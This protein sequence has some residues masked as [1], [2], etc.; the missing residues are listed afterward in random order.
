MD[1][2]GKMHTNL[3]RCFRLFLLLLLAR[4]LFPAVSFLHLGAGGKQHIWVAATQRAPHFPALRHRVK[5]NGDPAE[6]RVSQQ[7]RVYGLKYCNQVARRHSQNALGG[8]VAPKQGLGCTGWSPAPHRR[9]KLFG[10]LGQAF[11]QRLA[12]QYGS[13]RGIGTT[14]REHAKNSGG[15]VPEESFNHVR[16][17]L[18]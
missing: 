2:S 6:Q 1:Q 14:V 11:E 4:A 5:M 7:L 17:L 8:N 10:V 18:R 13:R 12:R 9:R 16:L 15:I 3:L